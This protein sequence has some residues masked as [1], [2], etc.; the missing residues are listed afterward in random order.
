MRPRDVADSERPIF[1]ARYRNRRVFKHASP[2]I[3]T[4]IEYNSQEQVIKIK[5]NTDSTAQQL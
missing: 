5:G 4:F 3:T 1:F 2:A